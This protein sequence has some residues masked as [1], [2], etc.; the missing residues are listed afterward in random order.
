MQEAPSVPGQRGG[1]CKWAQTWG[2][3]PFPPRPVL[4]ASPRVAGWEE[5][6]DGNGRRGIRRGLAAQ[7]GSQVSS[8]YIAF[9]DET[10]ILIISAC[11]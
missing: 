8:S 5:P 10:F 6:S 4:P 3:G 11:L 2:W 9:S 7:D 1:G